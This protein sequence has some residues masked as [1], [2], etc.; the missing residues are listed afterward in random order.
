MAMKSSI[1]FVSL[2]IILSILLVSL[3]LICCESAPTGVN[4]IKLV[5]NKFTI[6]SEQG[7]VWRANF[8]E[9]A[10]NHGDG[11]PFCRCDFMPFLSS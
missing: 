3:Q 9:Y 1:F 7:L 2:S 4:K 8:C 5:G 6:E 11:G 10:C